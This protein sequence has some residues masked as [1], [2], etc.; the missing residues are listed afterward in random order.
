MHILWILRVGTILISFHLDYCSTMPL[1][2]N[3][4]NLKKA[5]SCTEQSN[6]MYTFVYWGKASMLGLV[7]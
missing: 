4:G 2:A 5:R 6:E 1:L 3:E 7:K